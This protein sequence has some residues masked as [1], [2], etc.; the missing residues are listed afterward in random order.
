MSQTPYHSVRLIQPHTHAGQP[1]PAGS[2]LDLPAPLAD[3][4]R[5]QGVAEALTDKPAP[6]TSKPMTKE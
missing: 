6:A 1:Y 5:Q 4:L 2:Q 3:W